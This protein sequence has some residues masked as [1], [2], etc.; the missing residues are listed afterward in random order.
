MK[1]NWSIRKEIKWVGA[2]V[3]LMVLIGFSERELGRAVCKDIVV[4]LEN[5]HENHFLSEMQALKVVEA[6]QPNMR[7]K[8]FEAINL[9][10]LEGKLLTNKHV[11]DAELFSDHK[12]NLMVKAELRRPIARV[13][14][15]DGP[16]AYIAEDGVV[17]PISENFTSRVVIISGAYVKKLLEMKDVS[18]FE[19]GQK[20]LAMIAFINEDFFW[21]AQ[22][23]QLDINR[24]GKIFIYPQVSSQLVEFGTPDD[25]ETKFFKLKVFYKKILPQMGWTKYKRVSLEFDGQIVAE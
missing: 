21:K 3:C 11:K 15:E 25:I 14:R 12:G 4:E 10:D 19:E 20:I 2:F 13:V 22:V 7:G 8:S 18:K 17:M 6:G 5:A 24:Q 16:D 9:R 23:A 1:K